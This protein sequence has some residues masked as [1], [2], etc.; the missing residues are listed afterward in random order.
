ML[1]VFA[2]LKERL[3]RFVIKINFTPEFKYQKSPVMKMT[4]LF[5]NNLNSKMN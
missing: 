5:L 1:N 2:L 4:G 3:F